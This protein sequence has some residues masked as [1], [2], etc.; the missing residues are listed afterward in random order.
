MCQSP[1]GGTYAFIEMQFLFE[2]EQ[3][4]SESKPYFGEEVSDALIYICNVKTLF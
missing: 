3:S 1:A 2:G 4:R